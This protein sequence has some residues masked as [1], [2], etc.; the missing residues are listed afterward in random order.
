MSNKQ[1]GPE[2]DGLRETLARHAGWTAFGE[3]IPAIAL[4]ETLAL[5]HERAPFEVEALLGQE[6]DLEILGMLGEGGMGRVLLARQPALQRDVAVKTLRPEL[7]LPRLS[8]ALHEEGAITGSLEHPNIVPVHALRV[9]PHGR[10][11]MVMK[12]IE[13]VPWGALVADPEHRAWARLLPRGGDRLGAHLGILIAVCNAAHYSHRHGVVHRD[14]KPDNVM[15]GEVGEVYLVDWGIATGLAPGDPRTRKAELGFV[16]TPGLL[17]P[18][19]VADDGGTVDARTDVFLLGATL[20]MV[21]T[22]ELRHRAASLLEVL[23]A[24]RHTEPVAYGRGVPAALGEIANRACEREPAR[25]YASAIELRDALSD[26]LAHRASLALSER[27]LGVLERAEQRLSGALSPEDRRAGRRLLLES[28]FAFSHALESWS[29]SPHAREGLRACAIVEVRDQ[30]AQES[31]AGAEAALLE[32]SSPPAELVAAVEALRGREQERA[33]RELRLRALE[34]ASDWRVGAGPRVAFFAGVAALGVGVWLWAN[35]GHIR[36]PH[37]LPPS[38]LAAGV[39]IVL[40]VLTAAALV[41]RRWLM[42]T[43]VGARLVYGVLLTVAAMLANRVGNL[44]PAPPTATLVSGEI[45]LCAYGAALGGLFLTRWLWLQV[46]IWLT[47]AFVVRAVP[48][49]AGLIFATAVVLALF[50]E[51]WRLRR[52]KGAHPATASP[53][54]PERPE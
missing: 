42:L 23:Y 33:A 9:D 29:D 11:L 15:L 1:Q 28:R 5:A 13:G 43:E 37:P 48:G 21:L 36:Y 41:A 53:G 14:I 51:V 49:S 18:E 4:D 24:A 7:A 38:R 30:V 10:P 20:H 47:A 52:A 31:L 19:M 44:F 6:R 26:Y 2:D 22:G 17:A 16:G 40:A 39:A 46:P 25:R 50:L 12:R 8:R 45:I 34:R 54:A 32:V 35:H 3:T 27:A